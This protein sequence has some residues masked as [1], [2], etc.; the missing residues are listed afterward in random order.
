[1]PTHSLRLPDELAHRLEILSKATK[2]T[3]TSVI[4]EAIER[5]L[6]EQEDLEIALARFRDPK[7]NGS[8]TRMSYV[9][10][11]SADISIR[12]DRKA[13]KE[14]KKV[15]HQDQKRITDSVE[16]LRIDPLKGKVMSAD[17]K[18]FRRLR[19]G[20][21]RVIYAFDGVE[22]LISVF[23]VGHRREVYR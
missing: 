17:W 19:I 6:D 18:G 2:R 3:K 20:D 5:H 23:R 13:I 7:P 1:M 14:L 4:V 16:A 9:N 15:P 10:S 11:T 12:W 21:Y 22:L 8:T